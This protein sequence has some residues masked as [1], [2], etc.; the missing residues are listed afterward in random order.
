MTGLDPETEYEYQIVGIAYPDVANAGTAIATFKTKAFTAPKQ[1]TVSDVTPN[2]ATVSW[3]SFASTVALQYATVPD[4]V[5]VG[6]G[7]HYYDDGE[8]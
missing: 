7:W 2:A 3:T 1:L 5:N 6:S 4:N 8:F